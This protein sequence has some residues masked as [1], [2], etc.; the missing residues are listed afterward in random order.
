MREPAG[1]RRFLDVEELASQRAI[2]DGVFDPE[3]L[4]RL[5]EVVTARPSAIAYRI[6][7]AWDVSRRPKMTGEVK[8]ML[9]LICQRC[10]ERLD[11]YFDT[12]FESLVIDNE[13]EEPGDVDAVVRSGGRI[14]LEPIVEDEVLLALPNAPVHPHGSC[15][16]P[17]N[18]AT[19]ERPP[20]RRSN[21]FSALRALRPDHGR[22]Q[23]N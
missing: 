14:A 17:R 13:Q 21:P 10:L 19:R 11:W 8:G 12:V 4:P 18:Q 3:S 1:I 6:E 2:L 9:P 20:S 22:E 16:A 5:L 23:S 15:E 7:F